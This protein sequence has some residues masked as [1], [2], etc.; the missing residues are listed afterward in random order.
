MNKIKFNF[1][2]F[3][4]KV[5]V[6]MITEN[7]RDYF[8]KQTKKKV[9]FPLFLLKY[10]DFQQREMTEI[11]ERRIETT[12]LFV[13]LARQFLKFMLNKLIIFNN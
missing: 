12:I 9:H 7:W 13:L 3:L 10:L 2:F 11:L 6:T 4:M 1:P 5:S 8:K